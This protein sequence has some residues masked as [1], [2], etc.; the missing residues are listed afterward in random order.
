M[1]LR[2]RSSL[3][4]P[5]AKPVTG[6]VEV[7]LLAKALVIPGLTVITQLVSLDN[8]E[9]KSLH[10]LPFYINRIIH[11]PPVDTVCFVPVEG[12][13]LP[14]LRPR[15]LRRW[16]CSRLRWRRR[17][18]RP[19]SWPRNP[20]HR[21]RP[22]PPNRGRPRRRTSS[23]RSRSH[24]PL[25]RRTLFTFLTAVSLSDCVGFPLLLLLLLHPSLSLPPS[26]THTTH[27]RTER[28]FRFH[29]RQ[30]MYPYFPPPHF[31]PSSSINLP[32]PSPCIS[33]TNRLLKSSLS[34]LFSVSLSF[35]LA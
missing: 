20:W 5:V 23:C 4:F 1:A 6:P 9:N 32:R 7:V 13:D 27:A 25:A 8:K 35:H 29:R 34:L 30:A 24:K 16:R 10:F 28:G 17:H 22:P 12:A 14:P 26:R 18:R 31:P 15:Y 21:S 33:G 3:V 2:T 19:T 11:S